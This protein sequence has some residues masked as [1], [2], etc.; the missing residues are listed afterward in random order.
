MRR[1]NFRLDTVRALREQREEQAKEALARELAMKQREEARAASAASR[2]ESA[3][4]N[5]ASSSGGPSDARNLVAHQQYIERVERERHIAEAELV[6]RER[7]VDER[8][9]GLAEAAMKREVL[10]RM[11]ERQRV[12]HDKE[13]AAAE[14]RLR[15]DVALGARARRGIGGVQ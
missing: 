1:F 2:L 8:R 7:V 4:T 5:A 14:E 3:Q 10:E 12:A 15:D 9:D 13:V 11:R 6:L